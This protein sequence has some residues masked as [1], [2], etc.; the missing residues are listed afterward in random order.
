V[1]VSRVVVVRCDVVVVLRRRVIVVRSGVVVVGHVV[2][3]GV[4]VV[5]GIV[6]GGIEH[7]D[8]P[9]AVVVAEPVSAMTRTVKER[10]SVA[11]MAPMLSQGPRV[12]DPAA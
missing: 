11:S 1:A 3:A 5:T 2:V 12:R 7:V 9:V 8:D 10:T 6:E 4:V